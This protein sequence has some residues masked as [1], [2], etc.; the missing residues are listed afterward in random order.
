[1][2]NSLITEEAWEEAAAT[3]GCD[4]AA[5][6]AVA[7]VE[8]AGS[9]FLPSMRPKILVEGHLFHK[10]SGGKYDK[11][12]PTISYP[13]W[14]KQFY[15]GGEGEYKRLNEA[16]ALDPKA[17]MMATSWGRFQILGMNFELAGYASVDDFVTAMRASEDDH[18]RAFVNFVK[19]KRLD[20]AL[21]KRQW[22][23]FARGYNGAAYKKNNY[24]TRLAAS[25]VKWKVRGATE[26][27]GING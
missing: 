18:L 27:G 3:L 14:T 11:S 19:A 21:Q 9:G 13:N 25:Y 20:V 8:S 15:I 17:A 4:L 2:T 5:I 6:H 1:M 23:D 16:L 12:H 22:A 7:D 10:F 24:H 26:T